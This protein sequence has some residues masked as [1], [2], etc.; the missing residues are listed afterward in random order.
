MSLS[1]TT[2]TDIS[3]KKLVNVDRTATAKAFYE[4]NAGG[5]FNLHTQFLWNEPVPATAGSTPNTKLWTQFPLTKDSSVANSLAWK[6][7]SGGEVVTGWIPPKYGQT[8]TAKIYDS[9]GT[10]IFTTDASDWFF[11]YERGV[12]TFQDTHSF[13][14]PV[15]LTAFQYVGKSGAVTSVATSGNTPVTANLLFLPGSNVS[16]E[17]TGGSITI[18]APA[19]TGS[20]GGVGSFA[21]HTFKANGPFRVGSWV[22]CGFVSPFN[23]DISQVWMFRSTSGT[24]GSTVADL[25]LNGT[26]MYTT[27]SNRPTILFD[28]ADLK[29]QATNPDVVAV[30]GGDV[31]TFDI[32]NVESGT[33]K[34]LSITIYGE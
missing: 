31:L 17:Q 4:E 26:T 2:K 1:D 33:P 20:G 28:D 34:D 3:F 9:G 18:H 16:F 22:D 21:I 14:E 11:D 19:G 27:Q 10:Q 25:N 15:L 6:I 5:G 13:T 23:F 12:V 7:E 30:S 24:A 29:V 8:Y 32:D